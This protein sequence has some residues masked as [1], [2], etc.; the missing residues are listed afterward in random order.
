MPLNLLILAYLYSFRLIE[1]K[2]VSRDKTNVCFIALS[3]ASRYGRLLSLG[4]YSL[5]A[6]AFSYSR[7]LQLGGTIVCSLPRSL[8]LGGTVVCFFSLSIAWRHERLRYLAYS[9][10]VRVFALSRSVQLGGTIVCFLWLYTAWRPDECLLSL[11]LYSLAARA[12]AFSRSL[13]LGD[14]I[15]LKCRENPDA[16]LLHNSLKSFQHHKNV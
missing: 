13:Q 11:A 6:R 15:P 3:T 16:L 7:S 10:A 5:A 8:Q 9:L 4:P 14:T 12:F 2:N 1:T